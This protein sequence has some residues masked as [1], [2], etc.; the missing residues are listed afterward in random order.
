M[1][2]ATLS[3]CATSPPDEPA[4]AQIRERSSATN[5]QDYRREA[6]YHLYNLNRS[7]IYHGVLPHYLRAVAVLE[8]EVDPTGQVIGL[9]WLR[10]PEHAPEVVSEIERTV[11]AAAPFPAPVHLGSTQVIET[12]LW[13]DSGKFQLHTLSE[14]Q[15]ERGTPSRPQPPPLPAWQP[16]QIHLVSADGRG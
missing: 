5:A 10:T 14:G 11:R 8:M 13:D 1:A 7:R 4:A 12:W 15:G 16:L 2:L 9:R 6:A 3:G